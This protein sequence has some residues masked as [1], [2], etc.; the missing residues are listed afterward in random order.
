MLASWAP[1]RNSV[2]QQDF[3]G[4][5]SPGYFHPFWIRVA[6]S[7]VGIDN[8]REGQRSG[9]QLPPV[10]VQNSIKIGSFLREQKIFTSSKL[11]RLLPDERLVSL[12]VFQGLSKVYDSINHHLLCYKLPSP[13]GF[14]TSA[15]SLI[16]SYH[17]N[18]SQCVKTDGT[19]SVVLPIASG[20]V[21]GTVL[22]P[23][24]FSMFISDIVHQITSC[25]V[26]LYI[27]CE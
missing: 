27:S 18:R 26:H 3:P 17:S 7:V 1:I 8:D 19:L 21:Q 20:L 25:R 15:V 2:Q 6:A 9:Y 16:K 22:G 5:L 13:F 24:L 14:T 12:L 23:L 10:A 4:M 11:Q